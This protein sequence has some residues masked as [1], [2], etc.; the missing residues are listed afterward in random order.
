MHQ[1][2]TAA[3]SRAEKRDAFEDFY[4]GWDAF[5]QDPSPSILEEAGWR[6]ECARRFHDRLRRNVRDA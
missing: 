3:P 5:M 1:A 6:P 2:A 4:A